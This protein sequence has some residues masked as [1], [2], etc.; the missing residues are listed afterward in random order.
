MPSSCATTAKNMVVEGGPPGAR[1]RCLPPSWMLSRI[2]SVSEK[3]L[4]KERREKWWED[5]KDGGIDRD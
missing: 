2:T 5:F 1:L 4:K 3:P